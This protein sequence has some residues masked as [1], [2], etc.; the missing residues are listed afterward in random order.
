[1]EPAPEQTSNH[2]S[3]AGGDRRITCQ[4]YHSDEPEL[5]V[6]RTRHHSPKQDDELSQENSDNRR[7]GPV[8][9]EK[10]Q[11]HSTDPQGNQV[12]RAVAVPRLGGIHELSRN[13]PE[14]QADNESDYKDGAA[15]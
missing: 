11:Q 12:G 3:D 9:T 15:G 13:Q 1:M 6:L 4:H 5:A 7:A 2:R 10:P 14:T 8:G